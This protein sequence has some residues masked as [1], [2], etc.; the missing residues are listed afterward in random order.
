MQILFKPM[1]TKGTDMQ[2]Q[3]FHLESEKTPLSRLP[4]VEKRLKSMDTFKEV[5]EKKDALV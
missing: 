5:K 1:I 4:S 2:F 3:H